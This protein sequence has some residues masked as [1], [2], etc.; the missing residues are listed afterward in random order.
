MALVGKESA[1][2]ANVKCQC[3]GD[4]YVYVKELDGGNYFGKGAYVLYH[5]WCQ[6]CDL[7]GPW[8]QLARGILERSGDRRAFA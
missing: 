5:W 1:W 6:T 4:V 3:K 2:Q 8:R 7:E